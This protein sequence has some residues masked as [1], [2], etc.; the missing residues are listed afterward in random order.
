V[1]NSV[2]SEIVSDIQF[3]ILNTGKRLNSLKLNQS[4]K[5]LLEDDSLGALVIE[6]GQILGDVTTLLRHATLKG[7]Q[8]TLISDLESLDSQTHHDAKLLIEKDEKILQLAEEYDA[9]IKT[10]NQWLEV[11]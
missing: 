6:F 2:K 5:P 7:L 4:I 8:L 1:S 10:I 3:A 11:K 9:R